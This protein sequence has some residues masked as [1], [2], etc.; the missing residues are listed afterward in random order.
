MESTLNWPKGR[1][2]LYGDGE[3]LVTG[4]S[5]DYYNEYTKLCIE[6]DEEIH[7]DEKG[8]LLEKDIKR[9][10]RILKEIPDFNFIRVRE[11]E[12]LI[13]RNPKQIDFSKCLNFIVNNL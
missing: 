6:W 11:K 1:Y 3:K 4:Y 5:L 8:N 2:A 10:N 12:F 9:Q 7:F 13:K